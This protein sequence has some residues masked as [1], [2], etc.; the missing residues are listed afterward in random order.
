LAAAAC[1]GGPGARGPAGS[2]SAPG[3]TILQINDTYKIEGL[4]AGTVGGMARVR[5]L[6]SRLEAEGLQVLVLHA[7]D[8]LFPSVMSKYLDGAPMI[9]ALNLLDGDPGFDRRLFVTFGNHEFDHSDPQVLFDRIAQS[10]FGWISSNLR[11]KAPGDDA[12]RPFGERFPEV[13]DRVVVEMGGIRIGIFGLT[14]DDQP[15]PWLE[16]DYAPEVRRALVERALGALEREGAD[17]VVALTHQSLDQDEAL[18]RDFPGR[19]DW[20]AGGHE[21]VY[22]TRVVGGT[23]ITKADADAASVIRIDLRRAGREIAASFRRLELDA[24]MPLDPAMA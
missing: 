20:I 3:L 17:F 18:A 9:D 2:E 21:H 15:R 16:Y 14:L 5:A 8:F 23:T 10:R 11:V 13:L 1:S 7:G 6:R 4:R 12:F 22:L 24:S 19:I